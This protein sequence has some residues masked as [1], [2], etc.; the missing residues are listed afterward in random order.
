MTDYAN[1]DYPN[2]ENFKSELK[3]LINLLNENN[4]HYWVDFSYLE[5]MM[6]PS[7]FLNH[8]ICFD[9]CVFEES[10][11]YV[12]N[13]ATKNNYKIWYG[14]NLNTIFQDNNFFYTKPDY[15]K[16]NTDNI[17]IQS[18]LKWIVVWNFKNKD[19]DN[20]FLNIEKDFVYNKQLFLDVE[21]IEYCG[22]KFKIPKNY[23]EL[24][25]IRYGNSK[26]V[27]F[28]HTPRKRELC[29]KQ[30]SFNNLGNYK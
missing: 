4:I 29:E 18:M 26:G 14:N 16:F 30:Y 17:I 5:K 9:I 13:L 28:C 21:E 24:R 11:S 27:V 22:I 2:N 8:L 6:R 10:Y 3:R 7:K 15:S 19:K 20:V 12:I 23:E 25:K 1:L